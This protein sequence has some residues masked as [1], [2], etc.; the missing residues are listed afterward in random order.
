MHRS[1]DHSINGQERAKAAEPAPMFFS[2]YPAAVLCGLYLF[3][4]ITG[5]YSLSGLRNLIDGY[6]FVTFSAFRERGEDV[7]DGVAVG[8]HGIEEKGGNLG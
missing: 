5:Q 7:L 6:G 8:E 4:F 2:G 1:R 3:I